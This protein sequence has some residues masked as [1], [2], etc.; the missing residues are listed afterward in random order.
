MMK[1]SLSTVGPTFNT[2]RMVG[3]Y[4]REFYLPAHYPI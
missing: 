3:Q 4:L 2:H 1:H